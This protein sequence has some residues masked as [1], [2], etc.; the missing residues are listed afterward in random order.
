MFIHFKHCFFS[1][2]LE[3]LLSKLVHD[4][5]L[6]WLPVSSVGLGLEGNGP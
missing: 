5:A 3:E 1:F 2:L 4:T 6:E